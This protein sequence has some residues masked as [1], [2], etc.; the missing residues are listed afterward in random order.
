MIDDEDVKEVL[1]ENK[2][3]AE[4]LN[5]LFALVFTVRSLEGIPK[6]ELLS[7]RDKS[8]NIDNSGLMVCVILEEEFV[9]RTPLFFA[10]IDK[11][12]GKGNP[13]PAAYF[14]FLKS[15]GAAVNQMI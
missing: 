4:K 9:S 7:I 11:H 12:E 2:A 1:K 5:E 13:L 15:F 14:A 8:D 10:G 3:F 6:L